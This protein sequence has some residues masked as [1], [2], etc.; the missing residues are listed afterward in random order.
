MGEDGGAY[1]SIYDLD[2]WIKRDM[3][4]HMSIHSAGNKTMKLKHPI[5]NDPC[6]DVDWE[7]KNESLESAADEEDGSGLQ[8]PAVNFNGQ[9]SPVYLTSNL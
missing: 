3:S 5:I 7:Y 6:S 1:K 4:I 9:K 2:A 8:D